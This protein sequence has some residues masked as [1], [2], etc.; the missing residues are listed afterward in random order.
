MKIIDKNGNYK[1]ISKEEILAILKK[2]IGN[3][4]EVNMLSFLICMNGFE[5][6]G[7]IYDN[8]ELLL[9]WEEEQ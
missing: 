8:P 7:N 1:A 4:Q 6:V 2:N 9:N 5:I 3:Q